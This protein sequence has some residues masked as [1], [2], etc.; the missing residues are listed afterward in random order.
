M[1]VLANISNE[2]GF[3]GNVSQNKYIEL[4]AKLNLNKIRILE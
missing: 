2:P 4:T 3:T 1:F